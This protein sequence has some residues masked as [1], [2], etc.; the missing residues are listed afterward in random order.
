MKQIW[1]E[2]KKFA[3][4]GNVIDMAVGV[5]VGGAFGKIVS[6]LVND[7]VMPLFGALTAGMDFK[8]LKWV[9]RPAV[10]EN[11]ETVRAEAAVLYGSFIQNVVD[12]LIITV[13]IFL[14]VRIV[15]RKKIAAEKAAAEAA[16]AAP[17]PPTEVELLCEIRDLL[18]EKQ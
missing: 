16:A 8:S 6:S 11:G 15:N 4:K 3:L 14:V 2:F 7:I 18:K 17:K 10:I 9:I 13:S 12:F 1:E 5:I